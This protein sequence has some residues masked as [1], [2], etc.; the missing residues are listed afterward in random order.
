MGFAKIHS[1]QTRFLAGQIIDIEIDLSRGLHAFS[2]VGLADKSIEEAKDRISAAIK[3]SGFT[4]PKQKNQKVVISL[5][6]ADIQKV[7]P[8]FDLAMAVG[9]LCAS[10][11][12]SFDAHKKLFLG[13]LS[14]DGRVR[15]ISGTLAIVREAVK[16]NFTELFVPYE[17]VA[18]ASLIENITVYGVKTLRDVIYHL[19]H[20]KKI[21]PHDRSVNTPTPS[22]G[23]SSRSHTLFEHIVG[24]DE[25]KRAL[26]IAVAGAHNVLLIGPPGTGKTTLARAAQHVLPPLSRD[27]TLEVITIQSVLGVHRTSH[28]YATRPFRAPHHTSSHTALAGG[29]THPKPGEMTLAHR[30]ILFLD[31]FPE[32]DRRVIESLRQPLEEHV[33][34]ISRAK[35]S[36]MFPAH[37]MLI[38]AMNPCPCGWYGHPKKECRCS[39]RD[40]AR[41]MQKISGPI[42]DRIDLRVLVPA[43]TSKQFHSRA[44]TE[45]TA[46]IRT[47][48]ER[49]RHIQRGRQ[50]NNH[51][52][53][54]SALSPEAHRTLMTSAESLD[55]SMRSLHRTARVAQTIADLDNSPRTEKNH[56][57][58]A[59]QFRGPSDLT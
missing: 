43:L 16:K 51:T 14:L 4:S 2:I 55:L 5:A 44:Q 17:N 9:Y 59:L 52:D 20:R 46:R 48:I 32:F 56:V 41:Y 1:G 11:D 35:D 10:E 47:N 8:A 54:L 15:P 37:F 27:E 28:T 21:T 42:L 36:V 7:G 45:D 25:A 29:G 50:K 39:P 22:L 3:N 13:E 6:P 53:T 49:V 24:Q 33:V 58:E 26:E 30:G 12:I 40:R 23:S 18:E 19:Q 57:L 31:E 38:A 34:S